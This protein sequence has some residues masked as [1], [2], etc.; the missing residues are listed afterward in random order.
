MLTIAYILIRPAGVACSPEM[1]YKVSSGTLNLYTLT[2]SFSL[3]T[4]IYFDSSVHTLQ[5]NRH[6]HFWVKFPELASQLRNIFLLHEYL[7]LVHS[8]CRFMQ[9]L[10]LQTHYWSMPILLYGIEVRKLC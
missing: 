6:T 3:Y 2:L 8:K 5:D 7:V 9:N 1:T 10:W 4:I